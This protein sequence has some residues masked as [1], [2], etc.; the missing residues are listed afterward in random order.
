MSD[1]PRAYVSWS[2]GKDCAF[3]LHEARQAGGLEIVGLLSTVTRAFGRVSMHGVREGVLDLQAEALGL[4]VL[5][6]PIPHPCPNEVYERA[7]GEA[8]VKLRAEGVSRMIFGDLF[9]EDVRQ[10]RETRLTGTGIDPAF[11]LWG[12]DTRELARAMIDSGLKATVVSLDPRRLSRSFAGRSFDRAFLEE[13][14]GEVDPCGER[15]EFHTCVTGGPMFRGTIPVERGEVVE[16][17]GFVFADLLPR[18]SGPP[19]R[20]GR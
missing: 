6:V 20:P 10:Y 7:M 19:D 2:T 11:P 17:D 12:R 9:L 8:I 5:K 16:R 3:A 15:G 1:R 18:P 4:P 14:P 13:L